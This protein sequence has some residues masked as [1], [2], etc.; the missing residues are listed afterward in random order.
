MKT[1]LMVLLV[2]VGRGGNRTRTLS[3][4]VGTSVKFTCDVRR[5]QPN[6]HESIY[7]TTLCWLL[8]RSII[9]ILL[10]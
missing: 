2:L 7:A 5:V 9:W 4:R 6:P 1:T 10:I 3:G 8:P